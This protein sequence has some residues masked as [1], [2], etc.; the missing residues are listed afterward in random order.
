MTSRYRVLVA[1]TDDLFSAMVADTLRRAGY[2]VL[3]TASAQSALESLEGEGPTSLLLVDI[4]LTEQGDG[5]DLARRA[6]EL[7]PEIA[8]IYMS[9]CF[10]RV[11]EFGA[12]PGASFLAKPCVPA[13]ARAEVDRKIARQQMTAFPARSAA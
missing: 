6:R 2:E 3:T 12:V 9:S 13:V 4:Q 8:V 10:K 5:A 1:D 7:Q 11:G